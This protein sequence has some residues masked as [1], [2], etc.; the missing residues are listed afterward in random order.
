MDTQPRSEVLPRLRETFASGRTRP[1]SWRRAQLEGMRRLLHDHEHELLQAL[2]A[3]LHR[4]V[5]EAIA[6]DIG[7]TR[8]EIGHILRHLDRWTKPRRTRVPLIAMPG[9]AEVRPEPLGVAL[10]I[11]PWNYPIQLLL[12]PMA[13]AIAAGN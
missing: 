1:L 8:A 4:P 5:A 3:D 6:A 2:Y 7:H 9:R 13:A 11:A 12:E 10:V